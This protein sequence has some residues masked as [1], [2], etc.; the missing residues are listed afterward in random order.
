[1]VRED[2]GRRLPADRRPRAALGLG[3]EL[4]SQPDS[5]FSAHK[6]E[7]CRI[8]DT[9]ASRRDLRSGK[10]YLM[11]QRGKAF[12]LALVGC[13]WFL[14]AQAAERE[15]VRMVIN[16]VA[17]VKMPFPH[18]LRN[19]VARTERVQLDTNGATAACLRLDD[20]QR[21]CYEHIAPV[22]ARAEMLRVRSEPADG[23][24]VGQ[25]YHYVDDYDL[26]GAVDVGSTTKLEGQPYA[27]VGVVSQFFHRGTN[28][29]DQ[30][31]GDYQKLYDEGIQV[32]LR[33]LGE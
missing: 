9:T 30:F 7:R 26:D 5:L 29:G 17:G 1:M 21:W 18:N 22:G 10:G 8:G 25:V 33:Y 16:L 24:V 2:G 13:T 28:R 27:P 12:V 20:K 14:P 19:N 6:R 3:R 32:A 4:K 11:S 31:R 23:P 15:Q